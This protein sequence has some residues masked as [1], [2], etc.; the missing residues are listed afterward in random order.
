MTSSA[1]VLL[2]DFLGYTLA[3]SRP[4]SADAARATCEGTCEGT[5]AS[6]ARWQWIDDGVL[7]IEPAHV[8]AGTRSVLLSA[9]IHG[10]ETAPIELLSQHVADL[11][12]GRAALACRLLVVLGNVDAMRAARRYLDDDLNRLFGGRHVSAGGSREGQRAAALEAHAQRFFAAASNAPHA[13]WHLDLHTAIRASAFEQFALV[14]YTGEPPSRALFAW[15]ADA[16]IACVLIHTEQGPT[17]SSLTADRC[18]AT[19]CTL[20]LGK[21]QP[22]GHNDLARFAAADAAVRR[23]VAGVAPDARAPMPRVFTVIGQITKRSD[24]FELH[25]A[26]D[27]PNFTPFARGTVLAND[28]DYR[29]VVGHDEER[30]VFPNPT[31]KPGLRAGLL[32]VETSDTTLA[33]LA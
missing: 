10:D 33:A 15:L 20:E 24:A 25:V 31:V 18:G 13:R 32:V 3:G 7:L 28:G 2:A 14:P 9:G 19:S 5:C 1:D 11:A 17:Y 12:A 22:F 8:D 30:I 6:G 16:R 27:V 4:A 26:A 29:Y 23:L 21:V